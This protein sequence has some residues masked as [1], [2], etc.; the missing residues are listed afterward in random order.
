MGAEAIEIPRVLVAGL[1][2]G[3][4]KTVVS[5]GIISALCRLGRIVAPFKKGPDY[6]DA[7]W[8]AMAAGR[9][10]HNLDPFLFPARSLAASFCRH[11]QG[12]HISVI[13]GN[14][15]LFDGL[16]AEGTTSTASLAK[17]LNAPVILCADCTKATRTMAA[18]ILGCLHFDPEVDICGVILNRVAGA[19]HERILRSSIETH[20]GIPVLGA[21]PKLEREDFPERHMGL[22]PT[23]E[24]KLAAAAID[25]A[26]RVASSCIDL[27]AVSELAGRAAGRPVPAAGD[28]RMRHCQD[29]GSLH[30]APAPH[31][32][33]R[34]G[35][36]QD[37]AFQFYYPENLDALAAEGAETVRVSPLSDTALPGLD[38]LY[39]GGGFP[40]THAAGLSENLGF[41]EAIK[42]AARAGLPIYAE[43]GGLMYLGEALVLDQSYPM[44]GV[45]PVVFGFAGKPQGHG[46][47]IAT[48]EGKN[49]YFPR[50]TQ[51]K[52]HEFHYS[53]VLE[54]KGRPADLVFSMKK[55]RGIVNHKDGLRYKNVL[56]TYTH[57][58]S[59]GISGWAPAFVRAA[60]KFK[61]DGAVS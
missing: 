25:S 12:A 56:A 55:G 4:G 10:C 44:A 53:R 11:S 26:T 20:C 2:G 39:I 43:C 7:G 51:I 38:G 33:V 23:P 27:E 61:Q 19:R 54:W 18:V 37:S 52:G 9:P 46:Y 24:H 41:R 31:A 3:A 21:L 16:D 1:R 13:E 40:E 15:G 5:I 8:L 58:H 60:K 50:G 42:A 57:I 47:T 32:R 48:V 34:I 22:I 14:R 30:A 29:A 36:V 45:L 6:I 17:M 28:A 49:P 35:V 59:L